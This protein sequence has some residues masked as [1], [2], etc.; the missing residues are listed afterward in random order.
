MSV[1]G[2]GTAMTEG[3]TSPEPPGPEPVPSPDPSP[4]PQPPPGA[5]APGPM[6]LVDDDPWT[7]PV[8]PLIVLPTRLDCAFSMQ[9]D[10]GLM[11]PAHR[12]A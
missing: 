7:M 6:S 3:P 12:R 1:V 4:A 8:D 10:H 5:P 9:Y 2:V 11:P